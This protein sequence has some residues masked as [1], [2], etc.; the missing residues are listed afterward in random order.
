MKKERR[1]AKARGE[2]GKRR[3][4]RGGKKGEEFLF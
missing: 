3:R 4:R 2:G 1:N